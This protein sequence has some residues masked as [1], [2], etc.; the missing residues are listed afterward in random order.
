MPPDGAVEMIRVEARKWSWQFHYGGDGSVPAREAGENVLLLPRGRAVDLRLESKDIVHA[1]SIPAFR[2]RQDVLPGRETFVRGLRAERVGTYPLACAEFCGEGFAD[3]TATVVVVSDAE[4]ADRVRAATAFERAE[5]E[6]AADFGRRVHAMRGCNAC[7]T[8][9]GTALVGPSW[10]GLWG[11]EERLRDGTTVQV[12]AAYV[13]TSIRTPG[14]KV[15][16]GF[17]PL[18]PSFDGV[19]ADA[20]IDA[21]VALLRALKG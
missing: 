3:M 6:S 12:D 11:R 15:V 1:L 20:E 5:G 19:L 4:Y 17:E 10:K 13:E 2:L 14:V 9:D 16:E 7:H 18:M 8:L 21:V